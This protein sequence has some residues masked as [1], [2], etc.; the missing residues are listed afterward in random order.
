MRI[1][2]LTVLPE[3]IANALEHSIVKRAI[4]RGL[5]TINVVNLRDY[6]TDKHRTTDDM[7]Y[8]G[9]G[10][11]VMTVGP[12]ARALEALK[13]SEP[14]NQF[15]SE[16]LTTGV[17]ST[18][19][20]AET[21]SSAPVPRIVLTDPRGP[22]FTQETARQ[23][24]REPHLI[25]ICGH[26]EGVDERVRQH[27]VTDEISVGDF[28]LTGGELPALLIADA[29]TRLQP[30]ALGDADAPDKDTFEENLLEYPHYTRPRDFNGWLAPDVLVNG[31]HALMETWRRWHQLRAT[32]ERRPDLFARL[33][34]SAEDRLLLEADEPQ[35][36]SDLKALRSR[37]KSEA[38]RL[39]EEANKEREPGGDETEQTNV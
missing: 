3:M 30:G 14:Q 19:Q 29:L 20:D 35:V 34:L 10:G 18:R 38:R 33:V 16:T 23:W 27:L 25:L 6:T 5:V 36:P 31:H 28:I 7:P 2:I 22:R 13:P 11:M 12:I 4:E 24:A 21:V 17:P 37:K 26:Y 39:R 15:L 8:G 1:D 9:G 32:R